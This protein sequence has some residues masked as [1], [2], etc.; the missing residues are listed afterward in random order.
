MRSTDQQENPLLNRAN[1]RKSAGLLIHIPMECLGFDIPFEKCSFSGKLVTL[2][3]ELSLKDNRTSK[4]KL[5]R[6]DLRLWRVL[7]REGL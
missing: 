1:K 3:E 4:A 5:K 2:Q 6:P 7:R